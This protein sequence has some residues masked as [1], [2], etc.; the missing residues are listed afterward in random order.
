MLEARFLGQFSLRSD[1]QPLSL[2]SR[3]AQSLLAYLMLHP[4]AVHRRERLAGALWPDAT[5]AN[6]RTSLRQALWQ[7]RRVLG[8]EDPAQDA[9][10]AGRY[11][12]ADDVSIVF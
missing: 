2:R 10:S 4:G 11:L 5:E 6:A 12:L 3:P 1:G 8:G 9:R 7:V